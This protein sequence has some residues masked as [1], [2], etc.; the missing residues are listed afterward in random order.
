MPGIPKAKK[1]PAITKLKA[2]LNSMINQNMMFKS[3]DCCMKS[4]KD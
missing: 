1:E 2:A 3:K 4:Q